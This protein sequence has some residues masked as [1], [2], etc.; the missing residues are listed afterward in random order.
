MIIDKRSIA[1]LQQF[2]D[3]RNTK[4]QAYA[5]CLFTL[6]KN[7]CLVR[8]SALFP[9]CT[10]RHGGEASRDLCLFGLETKRFLFAG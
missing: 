6:K 2:K 4:H 10:A 3:K 9:L 8:E 1:L 7:D 5:W